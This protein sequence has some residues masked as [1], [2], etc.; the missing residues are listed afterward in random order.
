[1]RLGLAFALLLS[2]AGGARAFDFEISSQTIGQGYQLRAGDSTIVNRRRFTQYLGLDVYNVGPRDLFGRPLDR[3]QFYLAV[4]L[5]FDAE[6]GDY[7]SLADLPAHTPQ[8]EVMGEK[9]DLLYAYVGAR[10]LFGFLDAKLG[11]QLSFDLF[12]F[13]SFDG[14]SVEAKTPV[15]LAVEAWGGLNVSGAQPFDSPVYRADGVALGG[16][17]IGSLGARQEDAL[18][19]TFGLA[20]KTLGLPFLQSRLSYSRTMSPTEDR[21]PGEPRSGVVDEKISWTARGRLLH[22]MVI[23]WFGVRYNLLVGRLDELQ[24]GARLAIS[25]HHALQ[26]EYV[27]AA[28]TFDGDSIWNV[29]GSQAFNDARLSYDATLG[30]L[31]L[32][33]RGFVRLFADEATSASGATAQNAGASSGLSAGGSAGARVEFA[34]GFAR[35][36]GYYEDGFGGQKGGFDLSGRVRILGDFLTGLVFD[37]RLSYVHFHDDARAVAAADSLGIQGGLR[38]SFWKGLTVH[39]AL[40][41]NLNTY[42]AS[43]LRVLAL[44]DVSFFLA[45]RSMG[46]SRPKAWGF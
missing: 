44:L 19:P 34:R 1:V 4:S 39:L 17:P 7:A 23:P 32:F 30:R 43:Q 25:P 15:H 2:L 45:S 21:Q 5:R 40:E 20:V 36:D 38:Y 31:R 10:N 12:D 16:N 18:Q 13:Y 14:L 6:L 28:P 3:N 29:F 42:Y 8:R 24:A 35:A 22:G 37:G 41:E 27:F 9:L 46:L 11:R 33:A 26:A